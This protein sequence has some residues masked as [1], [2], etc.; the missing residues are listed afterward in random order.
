MNTVLAPVAE[1]T[2]EARDAGSTQAAR[3]V[4]YV[5]DQESG[6]KHIFNSV[7]NGTDIDCE[8]FETP[9][10]MLERY[11][12]AHPDLIIVDVTVSNM[13]ARRYREMLVAAKVDCPIRLLS[14]LNALLTEELRQ[15]W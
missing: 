10:T 3:A 15:N 8:H 9:S 6:T 11:A 7:L 13:E 14:G 4:C 1:P 2:A 5:V 12:V